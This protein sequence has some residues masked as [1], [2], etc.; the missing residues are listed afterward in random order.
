MPS[1]I[2]TFN[3]SSLHKTLKTL[4]SLNNNGITEYEKNGYIYD[5]WTEDGV[6][7]IQ[8]KNLSKLAEKLQKTLDT[9]I[10][11]TLVHPLVTT[12]SI[13][14]YDENMELLSS[15]KSPKK[16][17]IYHIFRELTKLYSIL[18]NPLFKL[19][20]V[21]ISMTEE[22]MKTNE[23]TQSKNQRRRF[24]KDWIKINKKLDEI[25]EVKTFSTKKDYLNLLPFS[26]NELFSAKEMEDFLRKNKLSSNA[27]DNSHYYL[28]LLNK[29]NLI[30]LVEV[31]NRRKY[32]SISK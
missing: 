12:K 10:K 24:K 7:E 28:W 1:S 2:N 3:E 5:I 26:K 23:P 18:L 20:I 29:M 15:R 21:E 22:R 16:N 8:T 9:G 14:L 31:K 19:E 27:K 17:N 4:Y 13:S 25:L 30:E 11:V 32:Y 6:I